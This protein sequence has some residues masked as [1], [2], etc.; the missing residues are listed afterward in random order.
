MKVKIVVLGLFIGAMVLSKMISIPADPPKLHL[1]K[2]VD[3]FS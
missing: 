1:P 2:L 3:F